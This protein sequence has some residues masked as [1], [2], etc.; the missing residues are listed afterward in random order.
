MLTGIGTPTAWP[1]FKH[2]SITRIYVGIMVKVSPPN[3]ILVTLPNV[4]AQAG[5]VLMVSMSFFAG[6]GQTLSDVT[7]G[8]DGWLDSRQTIYGLPGAEH[9]SDLATVRATATGTHNLVVT[10][11]ANTTSFVA[12]VELYRGLLDGIFDA[13]AI[14]Q[15]PPKLPADD[16]DSGLTGATAQAHELI[17]G[18]CGVITGGAP[19]GAWQAPMLYGNSQGTGQPAK[20]EAVY[21]GYQIVNAIGTYRA[22]LV[23]HPL[24][25]WATICATLKAA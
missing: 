24:A 23:G 6:G 10:L 20:P 22:N 4:A 21:T 9:E 19:I 8:P 17:V 13:S 7:W 14:D 3:F 16:A 15:V 2:E 25:Q 18:A 11:T 12:I 1:F 5:D